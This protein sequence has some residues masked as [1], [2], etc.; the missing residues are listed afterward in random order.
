[1]PCCALMA[2]SLLLVSA[3]LVS[4]IEHFKVGGRPSVGSVHKSS[5][6][7]SDTV[8]AEPISSRESVLVAA[9]RIKVTSI[10]FFDESNKIICMNVSLCG[11]YICSWPDNSVL[12][13]ISFIKYW[14]R[15]IERKDLQSAPHANLNCRTSTR[16]SPNAVEANPLNLIRIGIGNE[17][18]PIYLYRG[19]PS[20]IS[21]Q[22]V[23]CGLGSKCGG[24]GGAGAI[25][26]RNGKEDS[27][28]KADTNL[29]PCGE[30][31]IPGRL[32]HTPLGIQIIFLALLGAPFLFGTALFLVRG[33]DH[34]NWKGKLICGAPS[35]G[36]FFWYWTA[37]GT[38]WT[39]LR[40]C[41]Q[42]RL[43]PVRGDDVLGEE[44]APS[45][46]QNDSDRNIKILQ[47]DP[48]RLRR[49]L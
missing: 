21:L 26:E 14:D 20:P 38:P 18:K 10:P 3:V 49:N 7:Y 44:Q 23:F 22:N 29:P 1:M 32:G 2:V 9:N 47:F 4:Y 27:A 8:L 45:P 30:Y 39:A 17:T 25:D 33:F 46:N 24:A 31:R 13:N 5:K 19:H 41:I 16:I 36:G 28:H 15:L 6:Y 37:F 43:I 48:P 42:P 40:L 34:P 12:I 11:I 35:A